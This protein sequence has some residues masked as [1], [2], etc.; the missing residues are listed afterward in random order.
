MVVLLV[1]PEPSELALALP[2]WKHAPLQ[3]GDVAEVLDKRYS[4]VENTGS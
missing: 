3:N 4:L 2:F 1:L